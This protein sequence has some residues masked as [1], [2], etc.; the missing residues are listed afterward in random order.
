MD[1][2]ELVAL[3]D[4]NADAAKARADEYAPGALVSTDLAS[5]I[6]R[7]SPDVVFDCTVPEAHA[8]I[9]RLALEAGCHVLCEKPLA[10][11]IPAARSVVETAE[12]TGRM[13][14]VMQNRRFNPGIRA[15][16][17]LIGSGEIGE[18]TTLTADFFLGAHFDGFRREME[19]VLLLDMAIHTFDAARLLTGARPVSA[20]CTEWNPRGSWFHHGASAVATFEMDSGALFSYRGSWAAEGLN[21][22]WESS[23]RAIGTRGT[24]V[25]DGAQLL[26]GEQI[27]EDKGF[28]RPTRPLAPAS[29]AE[30]AYSGHAGCIRS[31][32]DAIDRGEQPETVSS[33]NYYSLAMSLGAIASAERQSTIIVEELE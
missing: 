7:S 1:N 11:S 17:S 15:Y 20:S 5:A 30:P 16:R 2:V 31:F 26:H 27:T 19:H 28:I 33:D 12:R 8:A 9:D 3:V 10:H 21:T 6:A 18:L 22:S 14:A 32:I 24:A 23:W 4:L 29:V 13:H 25:W